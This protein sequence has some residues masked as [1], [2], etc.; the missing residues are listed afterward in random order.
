MQRGPVSGILRSVAHENV[1][2]ARRGI[3]QFNEQFTATD[4]LDLD[5]WAPSV[6]LDNSNAVFEAAVYRGHVGL[7]EYMSW[8]REMWK[9]QQLEPQE[10]IQVDEDRVIVSIR[11]VSVGRD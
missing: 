9:L 11:L 3:E 1:D 4:G 10:F 8:V 5:L 6:V 7:H 2:I